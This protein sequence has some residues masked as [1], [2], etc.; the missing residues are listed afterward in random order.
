MRFRFQD[1][2]LGFDHSTFTVVLNDRIREIL[3]AIPISNDFG[4][5]AEE[6]WKEGRRN[7]ANLARWSITQRLWCS[8][9]A[10]LQ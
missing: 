5:R 9:K 3:S 8:T 6:D 4:T 10:P 2:V 1:N 7:H